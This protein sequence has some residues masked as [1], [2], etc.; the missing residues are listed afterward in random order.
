M[1]SQLSILGTTALFF[2]TMCFRSQR[3]RYTLELV[4]TALIHSATTW[5]KQENEIATRHGT[6]LKLRK[7]VYRRIYFSREEITGSFD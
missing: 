3:G 7:V 2:P 5:P 1:K 4:I 6:F